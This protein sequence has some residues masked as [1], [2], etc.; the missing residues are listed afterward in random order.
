MTDDADR[1]LR[2]GELARKLGIPDW[3]AVDVRE[4]WIRF[5]LN[6]GPLRYRRDSPKP[7]RDLRFLH[8]FKFLINKGYFECHLPPFNGFLKKLSLKDFL[9]AAEHVEPRFY[10]LIPGLLIRFPRHFHTIKKFPP[11]L[12]AVIVALKA[13]FD[14]GPDYKGRPFELLKFWMEFRPTDVRCNIVNGSRLSVRL[15]PRTTR[16]L[17]QYVR[18][19]NITR[20]EAVYHAIEKLNNLEV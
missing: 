12:E 11:D 1:G 20:S 18:S 3:Y 17:D 13:G 7:C 15:D 6:P 14:T 10:Q 16:I 5:L 19:R 9:W 4:S 2:R 8:I